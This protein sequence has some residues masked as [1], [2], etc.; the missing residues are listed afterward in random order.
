[1]LC[2]VTN[3]GAKAC[4]LIFLIHIIEFYSDF[5]AVDF[6]LSGFPPSG[7]YSFEESV[8]GNGTARLLNALQLLI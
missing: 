2:M 8:N 6:V 1:M 4:F 5:A 7:L 3:M